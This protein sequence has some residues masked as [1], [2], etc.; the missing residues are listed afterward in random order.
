[1]RRIAW[2]IASFALAG[3]VQ[4][5][6][7]V[8]EWNHTRQASAGGSGCSRTDTQFIA[9]GN[10]VSV[11][12]SKLG[13]D[14]SGTAGGRTTDLKKCNIVIPAKVR[15]GY[16]LAQLQQTITYGYNRTNNSDGKVSMVS[17]FYNQAAGKLERTIPTPG[18]NQF[19][20]P[21]ASASVTSNWRVTPGWCTSTDYEGNFKAQLSVSGYRRTVADSIVVQVDGH[22]IRFDALGTPALC[23]R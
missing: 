20:E 17:S 15:T 23:P 6:P 18:L 4:A 21:W 22:D 12:F 8:V 1:M 3:A 19:D 5:A 13:V 9:T 16:Y 11:I 7:Q 10:Q 14:L 2:G